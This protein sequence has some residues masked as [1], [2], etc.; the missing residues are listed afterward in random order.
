[1]GHPRVD[2]DVGYAAAEDALLDALA[3]RELGYKT[4]TYKEVCGTG[5]SAVTFDQVDLA[6]NQM[7]LEDAW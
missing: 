1:M 7:E 6:L 4:M 3:R 2:P 5:K